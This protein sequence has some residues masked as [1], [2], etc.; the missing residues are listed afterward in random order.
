MI[1]PVCIANAALTAGS[2]ISGGGFAAMAFKILRAGH[3]LK[4]GNR[5][6]LA[7]RRNENGHTGEQERVSE[8]RV[9]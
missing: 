1:C 7:E 6:D 5:K 3:V 4:F 2:A 9:A 8:S